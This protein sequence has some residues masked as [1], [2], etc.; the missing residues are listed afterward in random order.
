MA[1]IPSRLLALD[2]LRGFFIVIIIIDHLWHWPSLYA[3]VTGKGELWVT[4]AEGFVIISGL[5]IGYVRGYKNRE[6]PLLDVSVK[7]WKRAALLYLWLVISTILYT[8]LVWYVPTVGDTGWIDI[9]HGDWWTLINA[10]ILMENSHIWVHFLYIYAALLAF[11]PAIIWLLRTGRMYL[12][13]T[14]A[15]VGYAAGRWA[16]IEWMQWMP[17]FYLPAVAGFYLTTIQSWW[18][19]MKHGHKVL[20]GGGVSLVTLVTII[21]SIICT[22]VIPEQSLAA[23]LNHLFTKEFAFNFWRIPMSLLWFVGFVLLFEYG[24]RWIGRWF[25]W[26]LLPFGTRSLTAYI[27]HGAILFIIALLFDET[28]NIW[29]NTAVGTLAVIAAWAFIRL[30]IVQKLVP[31]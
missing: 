7:I 9:V 13:I 27:T 10:T 3:F 6:Q 14:L 28:S 19:H 12:V 16:D 11:T 25:G 18:S 5:L 17:L 8:A 30:Q 4:S 20:I 26:L 23:S 2:Y 15:F 29:Y 31:R 21:A 1:K 24:Q 22:F